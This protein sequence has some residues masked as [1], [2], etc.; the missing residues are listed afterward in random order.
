[1]LALGRDPEG[2]ELF[3]DNEGHGSGEEPFDKLRA[4]SGNAAMK[5]PAA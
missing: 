3:G 1:M 4:G 5:D 2:A